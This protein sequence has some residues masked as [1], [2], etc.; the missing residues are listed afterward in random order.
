MYQTTATTKEAT[1]MTAETMAT[2]STATAQIAWAL[3]MTEMEVIEAEIEG[4]TEG[5]LAIGDLSPE[6]QMVAFQMG[7]LGY[8]PDI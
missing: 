3:R 4:F 1:T 2:P 6:A 8:C 7:H 5:H